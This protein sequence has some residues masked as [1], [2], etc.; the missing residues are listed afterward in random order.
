MKRPVSLIL[1]PGSAD[2]HQTWGYTKANSAFDLI[3]TGMQCT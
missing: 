3:I 1:S 2:A